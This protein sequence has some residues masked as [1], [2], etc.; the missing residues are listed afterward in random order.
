MLFAGGLAFGSM[1][2]PLITQFITLQYKDSDNEDAGKNAGMMVAVTTVGS[3]IGS[4]ATPI[5]L[6]P[7]I[8]LM[9]SLALFVGC[10]AISSALCTV[11]SHNLKNTSTNAVKSEITVSHLHN[12]ILGLLAVV[13]TLLFITFN[14]TDTGFQTSTTAWFVGFT[15]FDGEL[16]ATISDYPRRAISSCWTYESHRNCS[17]YGAQAINAIK[18]THSDKTLF[19]GGAGFAMPSELAYYD[20]KADITVID[21]DK[22]LPEIVETHFLKEPIAENIK[23]IGDD[24]RG[25][26]NRHPDEHYDFVFIDAFHG[27]YVAGNLFTLEALTK[28][29]NSSDNLMANVIGNTD[30]S[31]GYTQTIL[32]NWYEVFGDDGYILTFND[33]TGLQNLILCNFACEDGKQLSKAPYLNVN[34]ETHTDDIPRLDRYAYR[35][36]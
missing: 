21:I 11:L 18:Q 15:D 22:D 27:S 16:T 23:F 17:W 30:K 13:V 6:L 3:V 7:Y 36:I 5:I 19:V 25:Y 35:A 8:G 20:P 28:F 26:L 33:D 1:A 12:Y 24:A 14:R 31:H 10:L 34:A 4:T 9:S 32:K 2:I 29:K